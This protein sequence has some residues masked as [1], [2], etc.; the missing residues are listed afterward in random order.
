MT[1]RG[2]SASF[3]GRC[4][5]DAAGGAGGTATVGAGL[6][7]GASGFGEAV[8]ASAGSGF[9]F[10][11]SALVLYVVPGVGDVIATVG[12]VVSGPTPMP[13]P[14]TSRETLS[15]SALT[16]TFALAVPDV[17]GVKRTVTA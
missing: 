12:R 4:G 10:G 17:V 15:P 8:S 13:V 7:A 1:A 3:N 16:L 14:V 11:V 2:S 5:A 9:G 6:T